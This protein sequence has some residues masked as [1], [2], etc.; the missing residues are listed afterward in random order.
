MT[1]SF[2]HKLFTIY[3]H[4]LII[5]FCI[6]ICSFIIFRRVD[7]NRMRF[8]QNMITALF[9][10]TITIPPPVIFMQ[11]ESASSSEQ[12]ANE[13]NAN[14]YTANE[15]WHIVLYPSGEKWIGLVIE[16]VDTHGSIALCVDV[17]MKANVFFRFPIQTAKQY[18]V[19][20]I[21]DYGDAVVFAT[22]L[23]DVL[24]IYDLY[25]VHDYLNILKTH[26]I[27]IIQRK[28]RRIYAEK[29]RKL[30]ERG[31]LNAQKHFELTG[32]YNYKYNITY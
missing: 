2:F 1:E 4:L 12:N 18:L 30:R 7:K 5:R 19:E 23:E 15:S 9:R 10:R 21:E 11:Q 20:L 14:E 32:N 24:R 16:V 29:M 22:D 8:L 13:S 17:L 28:W 3:F 31:S 25:D 26:W 27:R 6:D